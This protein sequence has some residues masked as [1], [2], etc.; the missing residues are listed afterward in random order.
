[1]NTAS[2]ICIVF[3]A[4]ASLTF[5]AF[6]G[7]M[8]SGGG[9]W[10]AEAESI[11]PDYVLNINQSEQGTEY[12]ISHRTGPDV[13]RSNNLAEV[14]VAARQKQVAEVRKKLT[15][16]RDLASR[17]EPQVADILQNIKADEVGLQLREKALVQ[18]Y[19]EVRAE[20][21]QVNRDIVDKANEAQQIRS[22]GQ[23]RREE[24]YQRKNQLELLRN[25]LFAAELQHRNLVE[26]EIRLKELL[27]R[28]ER[29]HQQL[30]SR[31]AGASYDAPRQ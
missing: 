27:Q 1:M 24:T 25:D 8:R 31:I 3:A 6:A 19:N 20:I 30:Q 9:N 13:K 2:R 22:Q 5:M 23:E 15:E 4:A 14:V 18:Q 7:A 16:L 29:R 21:E 17:L 10:L 12:R 28:L 26:E 11:G